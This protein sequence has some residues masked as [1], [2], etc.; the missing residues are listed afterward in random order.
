MGHPEA[1]EWLRFAKNDLDSAVF[2]LGVKPRQLEIICY[3]AQQC[4]EKALKSL[5]VLKDVEIPRT[6]DLKHLVSHVTTLGF[7]VGSLLIEL[8]GLQPYAVAV[9]YPFELD[10]EA[11][12]EDTALQFASKIYDTCH[13][14]SLD[15]PGSLM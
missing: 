11:G 3:H 14:L 15:F 1:A 9:R 4:A 10:L 13:K 12:D 8:A 5:L 7:D 6:H 2:L